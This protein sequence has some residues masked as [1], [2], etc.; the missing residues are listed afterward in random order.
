MTY[1]VL[2]PPRIAA[3]LVHIHPDANELNRVYQ[4]DLPIIAAP[5]AAAERLAE[6][7]PIASP[8]WRDW[9]DAARREHEKFV[10]VPEKGPRQGVDMAVV[11]RHL[12]TCL[13]ANTTLANGAGNFTVWVHRFFTYKAPHTELAPTSGAMATGFPRQSRPRFAIRSPYRLRRRRRRF[14]DVSAGTRH[15]AQYGARLLVLIVNNGMYG[16]IRMHQERRFPGRVSGTDLASRTSW[17]W[18][19]RSGPTPSASRRPRPSRRPSSARSS[20]AD[21]RCWS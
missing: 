16:T 19:S 5:S 14:P 15:C 1:S 18:R 4:A 2:E 12:A 10:A 8:R 3:R 20:R 11:I 17:D 21:Q 7:P 9:T 13:P 6:I